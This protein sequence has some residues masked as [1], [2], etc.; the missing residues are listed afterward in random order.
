M[1]ATLFPIPNPPERRWSQRSSIVHLSSNQMSFLLA[2]SS[3][4]SGSQRW[5][6]LRQPTELKKKRTFRKFSYRGIDLD[7]FVLFFL[8][9]PF[10]RNKSLSPADSSI[11]PPPNSATSY[12]PVPVAASIAVS[13]ASP[14]VSSR[15]YA[16]QSKKRNPTRNLTWSRPTCAT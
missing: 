16:K 3:N 10:C 13:N 15:N 6:T 12:T 11:S 1:S 14:W 2:L 8:Y 9:C 7:Q 5:L 4:C